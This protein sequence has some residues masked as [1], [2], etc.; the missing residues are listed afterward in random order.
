M[1][2]IKSERSIQ[3]MSKTKNTNKTDRLDI[4]CRPE[5]KNLANKRAHEHNLTTSKYICNL[6]EKDEQNISHEQL[7]RKSLYKQSVY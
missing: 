7:K 6:I 2:L 1:K 3:I 4:R 5:I